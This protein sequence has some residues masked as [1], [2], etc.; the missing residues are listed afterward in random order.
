M[1]IIVKTEKQVEASLL[2]VEAKVRYWE[3]TTVDGVIDSEGSLIPCRKGDLWCPVI[4]IDSGII[5]NWKKG[6]AADVHYKVCDQG[7]YQIKD[8]GENVL[9]S[10]QGYVPNIMCPE[11]DEYGD[12]IIMNIDETGQI[13]NWNNNIDLFPE[14]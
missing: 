5:L 2:A 9:L 8:K 6:V 4:D 3:D 11:D 10:K 14:D 12:Y 7:L 13:K 1:K